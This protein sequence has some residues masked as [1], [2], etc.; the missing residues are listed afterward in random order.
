MV[1]L[2]VLIKRQI[3]VGDPLTALMSW[4]LFHLQVRY[5]S[6]GAGALC[7][8]LNYACNAAI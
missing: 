7:F 2:V 3:A 8:V 4:E 6:R 1:L 5:Q